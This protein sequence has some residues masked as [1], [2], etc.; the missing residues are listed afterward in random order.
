MKINEYLQNFTNDGFVKIENAINKKLILKVN[1]SILNVLNEKKNNFNSLDQTSSAFKKIFISRKNK[2]L[3]LFNAQKNIYRHLDEQGFLEDLISSEKI[4]Q[5]ISKMLGT[6]LEY[7][8]QNEF[9]INISKKEKQNY[10]FK[11][12]H[13]EVW[14]GASTNTI[15]IWIPLFQQS[16]NGQ[17]KLV[18]NSHIWGH[19]PHHDK[20][21]IKIPKGAKYLES[22]CKIGDVILFHTLTLHSSAPLKK[23]NDVVGRLSMAVRNFKYPKN[24]IEDLNDWKKYSYSPN[25]IIEKKLGN[26]YLS[27]FRLSFQNILKH[28]LRKYKFK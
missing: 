19:I 11:K 9:I 7:Q 20:E 14:S 26:P 10:L 21:P 22:N 5:V 6:D 4:H 24:G 8:K 18:Q 1:N 2:N 28:P 16:T 13:Q 12:F 23:N 25:T 15:L 17:M 27:P 3:D